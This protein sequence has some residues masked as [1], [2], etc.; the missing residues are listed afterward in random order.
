[1]SLETWLAYVMAYIVI[2]V[3]PE[4]SVLMVI[5]Q[6]L[7]CGPKL[8]LTLRNRTADSDDL[9]VERTSSA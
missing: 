2:S 7:V 3:I 9:K 6:R 8:Q 1:M 4:P 5:G